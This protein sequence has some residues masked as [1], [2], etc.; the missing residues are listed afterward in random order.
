MSVRGSPLWVMM[1]APL[2]HFWL[3]SDL[4][5]GAGKSNR[6]LW[7]CGLPGWGR[8][9]VVVME[10]GQVIF[11]GTQQCPGPMLGPG[12]QWDSNGGLLKD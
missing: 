11:R 2:T 6:P 8:F 7:E 12:M 10:R 3:C 9:L 1:P 5:A 4:G